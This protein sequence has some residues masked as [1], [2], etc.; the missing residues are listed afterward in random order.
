MWG[1]RCTYSTNPISFRQLAQIFKLL[2]FKTFTF[3]AF[4]LLKFLTWRN[5]NL[6]SQT[7][8]EDIKKYITA[9]E[10]TKMFSH[11]LWEKLLIQE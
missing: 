4:L 6:F 8:E 2:G 10:S 11:L 9:S 3:I 1:S 7:S 5:L